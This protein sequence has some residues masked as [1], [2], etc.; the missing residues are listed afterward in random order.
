M[1]TISDKNKLYHVVMPNQVKKITEQFQEVSKIFGIEANQLLERIESSQL[2]Y[3]Y[4]SFKTLKVAEKIDV[5]FAKEEHEM[6]DIVLK[7]IGL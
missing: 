4:D 6:V 7:P 5:K 1:K 3:I 2:A